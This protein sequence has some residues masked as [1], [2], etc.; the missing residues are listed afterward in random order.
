MV[1]VRAMLVLG[2]WCNT[3][4]SGKATMHHAAHPSYKT[5]DNLLV[6]HDGKPVNML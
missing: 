3:G 5:N 1:G 4:F 6:L 2:S